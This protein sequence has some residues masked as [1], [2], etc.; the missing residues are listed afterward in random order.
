MEDEIYLSD[1]FRVLWKNRYMIIGI[2][3]IFVLV[4]GVV[5]FAVMSPSYRSSA[6]VALGNYGEPIYTSQDSAMAI[7][8]SD[9][10]MLDVIDQ[11]DFEVPPEE[12][13]SLKEGIEIEPVEGSS[14]LIVISAETKEKQEGKE[15]VETIVQLFSQMSE[16]SYNRQQKI[17]SDSL[18]N[19]KMRLE[20]TEL[21]LG[22]TREVLR[23]IEDLPMTSTSDKELRISRT[24]EYLQGGE[25]RRSTLLDRELELE[26]QLT[27]LRHLDVVQETREPIAP[28]ESKKVLMIAVAGMLGLMVGVLAAFMRERLRRPVE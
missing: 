5:S 4:A 7:M 16:E 25:S 3:A 14:S 12:F 20:T 23:S 10:Y 8:E 2:F 6:I 11:L 19:I 9:E 28:I 26:K 15:I 1:I 18:A 24:L 21:D 27:L 22:Q 13:R 17:L